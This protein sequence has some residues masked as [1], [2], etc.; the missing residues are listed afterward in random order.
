MGVE[1]SVTS[2]EAEEEAAGSGGGG[3]LSHSGVTFYIFKGT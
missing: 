3:L 2:R 1:G